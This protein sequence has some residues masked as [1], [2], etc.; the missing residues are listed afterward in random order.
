MTKS[1]EFPHVLI[2][3]RNIS[4][5]PPPLLVGWLT[6]HWAPELALNTPGGWLFLFAPSDKCDISDHA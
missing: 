3:H 5:L 2:S 6:P 1:S 4:C